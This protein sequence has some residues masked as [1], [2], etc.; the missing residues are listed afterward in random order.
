MKA[1]V[2][3]DDKVLADLIAFSLRREGFEVFQAQ[4]GQTALDR[5][6]EENPDIIILDVKLPRTVPAL[7][8]FTVLQRIRQAAETPVIMLTVRGE[9]DDIVNGLKMGADDYIVKPFSPRQFIARVQSVLRR[10]A[11]GAEKSLLKTGPLALD[12]ERREVR[13]Q[14][15]F[16][17]SL[18]DLENRLLEYLMFNAGH[19]LTIKDLISTVWGSSEVGGGDRDMLRQLVRRLR[20]K[21]EPDPSTPIYI[22]TIPGKGYGLKRDLLA[23]DLSEQET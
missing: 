4:N 6:R 10:A 21:I 16:P 17:I 22:E 8:G 20:I 19:I 15:G 9:E 7:D 5:W 3:D 11:R 12:T 2:V 18:T 1:L 14:D 23:E 13:I